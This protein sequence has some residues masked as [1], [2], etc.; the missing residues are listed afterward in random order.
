MAIKVILYRRVPVDKSADLK[1]LLLKLRALALKQ[2]GYVS[3]ETLMNSEDPEEYL[4]LSSW[5]SRAYW[6]DW[7]NNRERADVQ[8]QIDELLGRETL[9]Q[10]YYNA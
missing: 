1:P 7:Y 9:Y 10:V 2:P 3:G 8:Q 5:A 4:V 6:N